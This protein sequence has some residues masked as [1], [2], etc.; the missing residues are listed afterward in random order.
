MGGAGATF[1]NPADGK[2][3]VKGDNGKW[4]LAR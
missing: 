2:T 3:Y 4:E 1:R